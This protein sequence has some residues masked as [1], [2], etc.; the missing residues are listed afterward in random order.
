[1][2]H[3]ELDNASGFYRIR[4]RYQRRSYKRSFK[5][6]DK[7]FQYPK[8]EQKPPFMTFDEIEKVIKRGGLTDSG[9]STHG[10]AT[11]PKKCGNATSTY[12]PISNRPRST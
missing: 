9:S 11:G 6:G 10:W 5:T 12:C 4:F 8:T 7:G 3:L 2:P 1:M